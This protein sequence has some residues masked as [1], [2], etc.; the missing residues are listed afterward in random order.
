MKPKNIPVPAPI[1][2]RI[3][4]L[5]RRRSVRELARAGA[6]LGVPVWV[7]GGAVRDLWL[8]RPVLDVD[9]AVGGDAELLA[10]LLERRGV[11]R[12]VPLSL[13]PPR[14]F[15]LAGR[16]TQLDLA[17]L[18]GGSIEADLARRDFTANAIA[19][20]LPRGGL[21]DPFSG[22]EDLAR[23]RLRAVNASNLLDDPLRSLRAARFLATHELVPDRATSRICR[24]AAGGLAGVALERIQAELA[25]LLE[26]PRAG[27]ALAWAARTRVLAP[28]LGLALLPGQSA[29]LAR[30]DRCDASPV[31]RLRPEG[32]LWARLAL[33]ALADGLAP[34][35]A[36]RWLARRRWSREDSSAA[37]EL[38]GLAQA[39]RALSTGDDAWKW[40]RDA[41]A[42]AL[43]ALAVLAALGPEGR[44]R[45]RRLRRLLTAAHSAPRVR[46]SDVLAWL[47]LPPGPAVGK[48]LAE[49]EIAG[50]S[51]RVRSRRQARKWLAANA[52]AIIRSS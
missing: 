12:L 21:V 7:V 11:G 38:I 29:R 3:D 22:A 39:A 27:P 16:R 9:A 47:D 1:A 33:I 10:R 4:G 46:G 37:G 49:I 48:L 17:E 19:L 31:M 24:A 26:A 51:G 15:R 20:P 6:L 18:W 40:I 13:D 45:A 8:G 5:R 42:R 43:E 41:G 36:A 25:R 28:A 2:R 52:P 32:R 50:L 30:H 14:V 34:A 35:E 23:R 44:R